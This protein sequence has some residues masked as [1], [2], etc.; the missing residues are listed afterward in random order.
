MA[1]KNF[2]MKVTQ[3]LVLLVAPLVMVLRSSD[4]ST[5]TVFGVG[6]TALIAAIAALATV[7]IYAFYDEKDMKKKIEEAALAREQEREAIQEG[8]SH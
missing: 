1:V 6:L 5:P 3:S 8:G 7:A 2:C 4:N